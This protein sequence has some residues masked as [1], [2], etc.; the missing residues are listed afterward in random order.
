[1]NERAKRVI[2]NGGSIE[3]MLALNVRFVVDG[4]SSSPDLSSPF[5]RKFIENAALLSLIASNSGVVNGLGYGE[6]TNDVLR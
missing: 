6:L 3:I 5:A 2:T 1:M 4:V